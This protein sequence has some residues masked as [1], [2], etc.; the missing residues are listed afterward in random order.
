M[1]TIAHSHPRYPAWG[2][3][4]TDDT[5]SYWESF[6]SALSYYLDWEQELCMGRQ[7]RYIADV[8]AINH[9]DVRVVVRHGGR[10]AP[11]VLLPDDIVR[12][13]NVAAKQG[14]QE[15]PDV[16][17]GF[18]QYQPVWSPAYRVMLTV[19]EVMAQHRDPHPGGDRPLATFG[20][21]TGRPTC[22]PCVFIGGYSTWDYDAQ[23]WRDRAS[24]DQSLFL[25]QFPALDDHG[26]SWAG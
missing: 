6:A 12:A 23:D 16:A 15:I 13:L 4:M 19:F 8:P 14:W 9:D 11:C 5:V 24:G 18:G 2:E 22:A 25:H 3:R 7:A 10:C 1:T 17:Y 21:R 26:L 20:E